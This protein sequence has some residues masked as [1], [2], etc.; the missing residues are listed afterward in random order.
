MCEDKW[1]VALK[2]RV[3]PQEHST[4]VSKEREVVEWIGSEKIQF[5]KIKV[6]CNFAKTVLMNPLDCDKI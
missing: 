4:M 6:R 1:L 3:W 5:V 2:V